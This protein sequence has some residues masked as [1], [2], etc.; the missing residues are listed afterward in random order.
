M[1]H[2]QKN[3]AYVANSSGNNVTV[4]DHYTNKIVATINLSAT[5]VGGCALTP[6]KKYLYVTGQNKAPRSSRRI[7]ASD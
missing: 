4:V 1:A 3:I 2:E 6:D 5:G 7:C